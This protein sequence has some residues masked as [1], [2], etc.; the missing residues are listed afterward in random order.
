MGSELV[1]IVVIGGGA[2]GMMAAIKAA[3]MGCSVTLIEKNNICG[4][5]ILLTGKGRCNL[6]NTKKWSEF[7]SH[8]HP[9]ASFFKSSFFHFDNISTIEF[10]NSIGLQTTV[11]QGE[12]VFPA[13]MHAADVPKV[14]VDRMNTLNINILYN[15]EVLSV[16]VADEIFKCVYARSFRNDNNVASI[17]SEILCSKA[18]IIATGGLSYPS[19]GST[20]DGYEFA[21]KLSHSIVNTFPSLTALIPDNYNPH[22]YNINLNNVGLNLFVDRDLI[23][24]ELGDVNFTSNGIEGSLGYRV[25]RKAIKAMI[26]GQ[27]V[28]LVLDLKPA[29]SMKIL[30]E[31][32]NRDLAQLK[33]DVSRTPS[34]GT[35]RTILRGLMPVDLI[36]PFMEYNKDLNFG[37]MA[38]KLKEW[39]FK[40][41]SYIGYE[42][43]VITAG[44]ISR[45][46]IIAKNMKSRHIPNLYFAG[47]VIDLDGDTGGYNLQIAFS[48]GALAGASAAQQILKSNKG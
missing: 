2:A 24:M 10:F 29:L 4:K 5:K 42:R 44:G 14:L 11:E 46:D 48:T 37:N 38:Y 12:R 31:R 23:Q 32:I 16:S 9:V 27:K 6:T 3:E 47:E 26:N 18:M 30:T 34:I 8:I 39:R 15:S 7:S 13:S 45:S 40:I 17:D 28:E 33:T 21:R 19:T 41:K 1:D 20:G 35:L 22:L 36:L 25:S 43:A